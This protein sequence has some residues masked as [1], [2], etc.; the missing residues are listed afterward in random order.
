MHAH[1]NRHHRGIR[2][3][4]SSNCWRTKTR[5]YTQ[6]PA[7][8][9]ATRSRPST[10]HILWQ[11][12]QLKKASAGDFLLSVCLPRQLCPL[13]ILLSPVLS[14]VFAFFP[15]FLLSSIILSSHSFNY[16][17]AG[18]FGR[19]LNP[20]NFFAFCIRLLR[21]ALYQSPLPTHIF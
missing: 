21:V 3:T 4:S 14:F 19:G 20:P 8:V 11:Q 6:V 15:S 17:F 13:W 5:S 12:Q 18:K 1:A 7:S 16:H 2:L 9:L 10:F